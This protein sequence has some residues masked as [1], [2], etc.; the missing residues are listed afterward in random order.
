LIVMTYRPWTFIAGAWVAGGGAR[1]GAGPP[2]TA[3]RPALT[4]VPCVGETRRPSSAPTQ[5][6]RAVRS[7]LRGLLGCALRVSGR[8]RPTVARRRAHRGGGVRAGGDRTASWARRGD[9]P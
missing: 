6:S 4:W 1:R 9:T 8:A 5:R 2:R 3:W 7:S